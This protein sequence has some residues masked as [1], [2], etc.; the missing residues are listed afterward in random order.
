MYPILSLKWT[1]GLIGI[2]LPTV[3]VYQS[4]AR[5]GNTPPNARKVV[6]IFDCDT[7]IETTLTGDDSLREKETQH[8]KLLLAPRRKDSEENTLWEIEV[9][10]LELRFDGENTRAFKYPCDKPNDAE[11][12]ETERVRES[13]K[14]AKIAASQQKDGSN[15]ITQYRLPLPKAIGLGVGMDSLLRYLISENHIEYLANY[16]TPSIPQTIMKGDRLRNNIKAKGVATPFG[17]MMSTAEY[18]VDEVDAR[19]AK[20]RIRP[21]L[22]YVLP[23]V[24]DAG[25]FRVVTGD[26]KL[27]ESTGSLLYDRAARQT[28]ELN[29]AFTVEGKWSVMI[30]ELKASITVIQAHKISVRTLESAR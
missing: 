24:Q 3:S 25:Q 9:H 18:Q 12:N 2:L 19:H 13:L 5:L 26:V 28:V 27:K 14:G 29:L 7:T 11:S 4:E 1:M 22:R 6:V 16:A 17:S 20:M 15:K 23:K 21:E 30:G 8:V 10:G